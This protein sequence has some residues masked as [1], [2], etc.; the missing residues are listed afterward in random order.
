M[1]KEYYLERN[2]ILDI[3]VK[4]NFEELKE[5]FYEIVKQHQLRGELDI[6]FNGIT[7]S[8]D[9][10]AP[11][12]QSP[13]LTPSPAIFFRREMGD[14]KFKD[15]EN[16]Y[17]DYT[18]E[19]LFTMIEIIYDHLAIYNFEDEEIVSEEVKKTFSKDINA[20]LKNYKEGYILNEKHGFVMENLNDSIKEL[21]NEKEPAN[22]EGEVLSRYHFALKKYYRA[23]SD[24]EEKHSAIQKLALITESFRD[25][26]KKIWDSNVGNTMDH[27]TLLFQVVN[28]FDIRHDNDKQLRDYTKEIWYDWMIQY[29]A[30]IIITYYRLLQKYDENNELLF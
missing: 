9:G 17:K 15:I 10:E 22:M 19:Q 1:G 12:Y 26:L 24:L 3:N 21:I 28:K 6:A 7:A 2:G 11:K 14:S 5:S 18:E 4:L 16:T 13:T 23:G 29:H 27:D 20:I 8:I 25:E 30:S